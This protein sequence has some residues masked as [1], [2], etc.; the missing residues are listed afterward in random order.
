MRFRA[1]FT[2][3]IATAGALLVAAPV[4]DTSVAAP[5]AVKFGSLYPVC[6]VDGGPSRATGMVIRGNHFTCSAMKCSG[7]MIFPRRKLPG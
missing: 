6:K 3:G 2:A 5:D 1:L 7:S 4:E